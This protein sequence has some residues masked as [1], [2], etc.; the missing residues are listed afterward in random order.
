[1]GGEISCS[2]PARIGLL[3]NPSDGYYGQC[4]SLPVWNWQATVTLTPNDSATLPKN[5]GLRRIMEPTLRVFEGRFGDSKGF[6]AAVETTIPRQVGLAGSSAIETA[7]VLSLMAHNDIPLD[8]LS[9]REL[10]ELVLKV[11]SEEL[12]VVAGLQDCLPLAYGCMLHMDFRQ[13]LMEGRGYGE[14]TELDSSLLPPLWL[15]HAPRGKDSGETHASLASRWER[16]DAE[17]VEIVEHLAQG[18]ASGVDSIR[19]QEHTHL[20]MLIDTNFELRRELFGEQAL[21]DT[22]DAVILARSLGSCAK[23]TGSGGAIFGIVPHD[24]FSSTA[25]PA[26]A[27]IGWTFHDDLEVG[28]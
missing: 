9:S 6:A 8:T 26:F 20:S 13:E 17:M 27:E 15:A 3:G 12:G 10:A 2:V 1:M 24:D 18:A 14:Y 25:A 16:R 7:F 19:N 28:N 5:E 22:L 11:E 21:G 4:I 23:Q